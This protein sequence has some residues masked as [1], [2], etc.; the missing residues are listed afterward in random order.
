MKRVGSETPVKELR[1]R[2]SQRV[3]EPVGQFA[4]G[5]LRQVRQQLG[6]IALRIHVMPAA[7]AGQDH[8]RHLLEDRA[9]AGHSDKIPVSAPLRAIEPVLLASVVSQ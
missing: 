9:L 7:G 5:D 6:E 8:A 1:R 4:S 3:W 2:S